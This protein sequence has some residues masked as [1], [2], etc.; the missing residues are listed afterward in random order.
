MRSIDSQVVGV[1]EMARLLNELKSGWG[2]LVRAMMWNQRYD[3]LG[4]PAENCAEV[5]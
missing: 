4:N 5:S 2:A 1:L 3:G